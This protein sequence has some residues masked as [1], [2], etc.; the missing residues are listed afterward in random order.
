M[1]DS[2]TNSS[3]TASN[4][5]PETQEL[6]FLFSIIRTSQTQ[7]RLLL[8]RG[9]AATSELALILDSMLTP[10][11]LDDSEYEDTSP[12]EDVQEI[13]STSESQTDLTGQFR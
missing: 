11:D 13:P 12:A 7:A 6:L 1:P 9:E 3:E 10:Q 8:E 5:W 2:S 4:L